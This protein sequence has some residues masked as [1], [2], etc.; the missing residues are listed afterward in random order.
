MNLRNRLK[1][2]KTLIKFKKRKK[3]E[4]RRHKDTKGN[5]LGLPVGRA[6]FLQFF[7]EKSLRVVGV[8]VVKNLKAKPSFVQQKRM[9]PRRHKDTK[10][11]AKKERYHQRSKA[12]KHKEKLRS[13]FFRR[14]K[15][16]VPLCLCGKKQKGKAFLYSTKKN[17]T[18][19]A[20]RTQRKITFPNFFAE[21]SLRVLWFFVVE[22][23]PGRSLSPKPP[24]PILKKQ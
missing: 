4:P 22:K 3:R 23:K 10:R 7:V 19:K 20:P 15:T 6:S 17:D 5:P 14:K 8:F 12:Q 1:R 11:K 18:T 13:F 2:L 16:F 24:I 9:W 21:K